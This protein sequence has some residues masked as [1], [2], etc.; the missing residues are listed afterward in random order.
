MLKCIEIT[1][2]RAQDSH[3]KRIVDIWEQGWYQV[4]PT[5]FIDDRQM[6]Q[7]ERNF[8]KRNFPFDFW[9]VK[10]KE[11]IVGWVSVLQAFY[12]PMKE[13]FEAEISI[14][15]D[16]S[17]SNRG[18]GSMITSYVLDELEYSDI[19]T[20]WAFVSKH[21]QRSKK[22]CEKAGMRVCGATSKKYLM[23]K[24]YND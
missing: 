24:E 8:K 20:V 13:N 9:V 2:D 15:I 5:T 16:K 1:I 4:H 23:I 6:N 18:F 22:M 10:E 3:L 21:N 11:K 19:Q 14:Y 7:F 17:E 12:H